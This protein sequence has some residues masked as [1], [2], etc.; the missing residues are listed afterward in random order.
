M[1]VEHFTLRCL[2]VRGLAQ[3]T[4]LLLQQFQLVCQQ[5]HTDADVAV[6]PR[7]GAGEPLVFR[8]HGCKIT[9]FQIHSS[10]SPFRGS[11]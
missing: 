7:Q 10:L 8:P 4:K 9:A 6:L 11:S 2:R 3:G 1:A 5:S